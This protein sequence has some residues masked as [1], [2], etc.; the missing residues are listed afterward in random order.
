MQNIIL[1]TIRLV[2]LYTLAYIECAYN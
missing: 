2:L 1:L